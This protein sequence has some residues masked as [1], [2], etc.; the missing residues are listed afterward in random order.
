MEICCVT[1]MALYLTD[2]QYPTQYMVLR[3]TISTL[4]DPHFIGNSE[5]L[6]KGIKDLTMKSNTLNDWQENI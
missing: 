6:S 4:L 1:E 5:I 3:Q 2:D